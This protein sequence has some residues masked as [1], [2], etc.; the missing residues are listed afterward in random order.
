[1]L[2]DTDDVV[3]VMKIC[4]SEASID[5]GNT[6]MAGMQDY[7]MAGMSESMADTS[8]QI[9]AVGDSMADISM[10]NFDDSIYVPKSSRKEAVPAEAVN[11][12][13]GLKQELGIPNIEV[14]RPSVVFNEEDEEDYDSESEASAEEAE[15]DYG[16]EVESPPR[17]DS[18]VSPN[19][20][21]KTG[22]T[23]MDL[24][25]KGMRKNIGTN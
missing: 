5:M 22:A 23:L 21:G 11:I 8:V 25:N 1:M 24:V 3:K 13:D 7:S 2:S 19:G 20:K 18:I 6:S 15:E 16:K 17:R 14:N 10:A 4:A 9:L 12:L